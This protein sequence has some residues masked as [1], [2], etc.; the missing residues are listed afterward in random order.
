LE[1][2]EDEENDS[3]YDGDDEDE[4][5]GV[6]TISLRD[7]FHR[8]ALRS[9]LFLF[10]HQAMYALSKVGSLQAEVVIIRS[11]LQAS[12]TPAERHN[13]CDCLEDLDVVDANNAHVIVPATLSRQAAENI[14]P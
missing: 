6:A 9:Q 7:V 4:D 8:L 10:M 3:H 11:R 13:I 12:A 1:V 5:E 14:M 2:N